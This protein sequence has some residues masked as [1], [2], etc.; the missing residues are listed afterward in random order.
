MVSTAV[1]AA[2]WIITRRCLAVTRKNQEAI[3]RSSLVLGE[4]RRVLELVAHGASLQE[5]LNTLTQAVERLAPGCLC[6]ILL[7]DVERRCLVQGA[8]PSLP[9][10][11]WA[12][13]RDIPIAPDVGSCASAA[14][15]NQVTVAEDIATDYRWAPIRDIALSYGLR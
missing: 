4:E 10:G 1:F 13:C 14:F 5:I 3:E 8:A 7:V 9:A 15:S 11:W 2:L 6:S 12:M